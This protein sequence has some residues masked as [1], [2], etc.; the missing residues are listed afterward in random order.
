MKTVRHSLYIF[1]L[2]CLFCLGNAYGATSNDDSGAKIKKLKAEMTK[3]I[4]TGRDMEKYRKSLS[5]KECEEKAAKYVAAADQLREDA[6]ALPLN[7][8][9]RMAM[10]QLPICVS[11]EGVALESCD[12][13]EFD[14]RD[15]EK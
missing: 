8:D 1:I 13:I 11:C 2:I 3:L 5:P 15:M 7:V 9:L 6:M 10:Y 4:K 14:L 12:S